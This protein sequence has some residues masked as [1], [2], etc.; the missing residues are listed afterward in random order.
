MTHQH[1]E[2]QKDFQFVT[3]EPYILKKLAAVLSAVT[4][5]SSRYIYF[6]MHQKELFMVMNHLVE[7]KNSYLLLGV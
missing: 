7:L 6:G 3:L 4:H 1:R 2:I 5:N